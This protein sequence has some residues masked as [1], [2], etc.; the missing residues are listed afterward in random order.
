M[1][2]NK[3][4]KSSEIALVYDGLSQH[5][6]TGWG[7]VHINARHNNRTTTNVLFCDGHVESL[8]RNAMPLE[9]GAME[10]VGLLRAKYAYPKW[11]V[12]Q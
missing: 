6:G 9:R 4:R 3:I 11:R 1:K 5:F 10:D 8:P 7:Y 2:F 12:D